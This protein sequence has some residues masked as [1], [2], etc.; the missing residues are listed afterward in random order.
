MTVSARVLP[1]DP[2]W[3]VKGG[4]IWNIVCDDVTVNT[5]GSRCGPVR[6][7]WRPVPLSGGSG[8]QSTSMI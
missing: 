6:F 4:T 5:S 3:R 2:R 1:G 8:P 7:E